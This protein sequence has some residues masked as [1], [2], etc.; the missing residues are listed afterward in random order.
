MK[1]PENQRLPQAPNAAIA[2]AERMYELKLIVEHTAAD[3]KVIFRTV[4]PIKQIRQSAME[5]CAQAAPCGC[6]S[7]QQIPP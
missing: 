7:R 2:V 1:A 3:K 5:P 4:Q 6:T